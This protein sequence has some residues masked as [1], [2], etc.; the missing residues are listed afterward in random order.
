[1]SDFIYTT[2]IRKIRRIDNLHKLLDDTYRRIKVIQGGTSAGKT[3]AII[4]ILIDKAIK[5]GGTSISIVS[6]SFPHLRKG[7][8]RDFINIMK[9]TNRYIDK[10]WNRTNSIY[11]FSNGSYVEFFSAESA[12]KLRGARRNILFV[13]E[14]NN[15]THEAYSQM[16]MRTDEDI[17]LDYN[18]SHKFWIEDVLKSNEAYKIILTYKDNEALS[19]TIIKFLESKRDL[20]NTSEYWKNWCKVYLDGQQGTLEGVIFDNWKP[21]DKIP[22]EARLLAYGLDWGYTNDPTTLI[23]VYK[24]ND[25]IILDELIYKTGLTNQDIIKELKLLNISSRE[26]IY[27]DSAEPKSIKEV[28][29]GGFRTLPTKKGKDSIVYGIQLMLGEKFLVTKN[30]RNLIMELNRYSWKIDRSGVPINIPIDNYNHGIDAVR[31]VFQT[32]LANKNKKPGRYIRI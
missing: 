19:D 3:F 31:Y 11:T 27:C 25:E 16:A 29:L 13:N 26:E 2:A 8:M 5:K 24:Y 10:N 22:E 21:I 4:P 32:K 30:S 12:D 23:G 6:E 14:C 15:I 28:S 17:Y 18:P 9:M 1:M 20:A 7:A